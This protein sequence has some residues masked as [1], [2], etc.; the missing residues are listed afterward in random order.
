MNDDRK[1]ALSVH[2]KNKTKQKLES[3][4]LQEVVELLTQKNE[5]FK[6]FFHY[7]NIID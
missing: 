5:L 2:E 4:H 1:L 6:C 7:K 3:D